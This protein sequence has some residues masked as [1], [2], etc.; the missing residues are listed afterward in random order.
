MKQNSKEIE[1]L[2]SVD[3]DSALEH[4][5]R[6]GFWEKCLKTAEKEVISLYGQLSRA[7]NTTE[8]QRLHKYV[9]MYAAELIKTSRVFEALLLYKKYGCP[10]FKQN[11]NIYKRIFQVRLI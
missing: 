5:A 11:F 6:Q 4:Y 7:L 1:A 9:A 2:A 8:Y 10:S 3:V